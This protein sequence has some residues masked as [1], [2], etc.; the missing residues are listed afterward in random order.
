MGMEAIWLLGDEGGEG[1]GEGE[2]ERKG[3]ERKRGMRGGRK[4]RR[5]R[6]GRRG[7]VV[8]DVIEWA[9][10][11]QLLTAAYLFKMSLWRW[12]NTSPLMAGGNS[13]R[14]LLLRFSLERL[15]RGER[16]GTWEI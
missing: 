2:K 16:R 14:R 8:V 3:R 4:D 5:M 11:Q 12:G 7:G 1:R 9:H 10:N 15:G 13:S 6:K